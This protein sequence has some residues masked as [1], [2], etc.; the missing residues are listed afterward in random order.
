MSYHEWQDEDDMYD[1]LD[2]LNKPQQN[3]DD[4][5]EDYVNEQMDKG[6]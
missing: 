3:P 4:S 1:S 2:R 6:E 5:Y